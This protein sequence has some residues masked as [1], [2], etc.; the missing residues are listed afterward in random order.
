MR[1][2]RAAYQ[3]GEPH[4]VVRVGREDLDDWARYWRSPDGQLEA[5]HAHF[6]GHVYHRHSHETYSFGL[7]ETGAAAA[8]PAW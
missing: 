1:Y 6:R 8:P 5:M 7:T 3:A 4:T 2:A